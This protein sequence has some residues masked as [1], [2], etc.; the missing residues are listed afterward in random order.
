MT[1]NA[2]SKQDTS[3]LKGF[4]ILCICLHNFF[5]HL[6]PSPG[7]NEFYFSINHINNFISQLAETPSEFVNILFSYLGHFGVQIFIFISGFGLTISMMNRPKPWIY[8]VIDRLKKLY[9]LLLTAVISFILLTI[10]MYARLPWKTHFEEINYKLLLIHTLLPNQGT[11]VNGPWWFF[12]LIFQL[13]L[14][15]PLLFNLIKRF[16]FKALIII[17]LASYTWIFISQYFFYDIHEVYLL[18]N[19]PGHLPEFCLGIFLAFK[20]NIK[21]NNV[22]FFI[23]LVVFSLGNYFKFFFP[24]TFLSVTIISI[25]IYQFLKN[26]PI[27]KKILRLFLVNLGNVSMS[28]FVIHGFM[29]TPFLK[30][31]TTSMNTALGHICSALLFFVTAYF[32]SFAA[33]HLYNILLAIFDKIKFKEKYNNRMMIISRILQLS[34]VAFMLYVVYYVVSQSN[35]SMAKQI[36]EENSIVENYDVERDSVYNTFASIAMEER[37]KTIMISGEM[38]IRS[39]GSNI[40]MPPIVVEINDVLWEKIEIPKKYNTTDFNT[41][42]FKY[43]FYCP[44]TENLKGKTLKLYFWNKQKSSIELNNIDI[45]ILAN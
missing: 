17:C 32:V 33:T 29:R 1:I 44:F 24:F 21:I 14:I 42:D 7:E 6:A 13:Y 10:L 38:D 39:V 30:L 45:S 25:F 31:A 4:A 5:H 8:F 27:N 19:F 36:V 15:F 2:Y 34:I 41:F 35:Y 3:V 28:L 37:Y 26:I 11:S 18:Q 43:T 22:I 40:S 9:P 20:K 16:D 23:A 12:G